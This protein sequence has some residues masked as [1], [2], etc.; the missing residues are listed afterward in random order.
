MAAVIKLILLKQRSEKVGAQGVL[1]STLMENPYEPCA[2]QAFG[3]AAAGAT[4]G[5]IAS[6]FLSPMYRVTVTG[7]PVSVPPL[8]DEVQAFV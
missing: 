1:L 8:N 2:C 4:K 5:G 7:V 6:L 3:M